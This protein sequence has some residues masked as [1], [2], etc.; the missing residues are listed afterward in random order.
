MKSKKPIKEKK[1]VIKFCP[2]CKSKDVGV[3][4]GGKI[5]MW[6]CHKCGFRAPGFPE[7]EVSE[8]EFLKGLDEEKN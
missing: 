8:E 4:I 3:M 6:E 2:N 5:G 1:F 7:I